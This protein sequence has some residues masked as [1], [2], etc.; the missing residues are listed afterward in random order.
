M[1]RSLST[2]TP[3][4]TLLSPS[5]AASRRAAQRLSA[6]TSFQ[7]CQETAPPT[8]LNQVFGVD[9]S[10]NSHTP[11]FIKSLLPTIQ[12]D[13][14][15][16]ECSE[17][18]TILHWLS[19][20]PHQQG[21]DDNHND[22]TLD[23]PHELLAVQDVA[24]VTAAVERI[25]AVVLQTASVPY[26]SMRHA[27]VGKPVTRM[28]LLANSLPILHLDSNNHS[29]SNRNNSS[30]N[31]ASRTTLPLPSSR[32]AARPS[33]A[34]GWLKEVAIPAYNDEM[35]LA[36]DTLMTQFTNSSLARPAVGLYQLSS[37]NSSNSNNNNLCLRPLPAAKE[38]RKLPPPSLVFSTHSVDHVQ[39]LASAMTVDDI[40]ETNKD[41]DASS[42]TATVA[43][44]R[45]GKI[46]YTG[47]GV[48]QIMLQ[49]TDWMGLDVRFCQATK[50]S[51]M[52]AEAQESLL[53]GSLAEL[54]SPHVLQGGSKQ[55]KEGDCWAEFRA[56]LK[57]PSGFL[58]RTAKPSKIAKAP[59]LPYE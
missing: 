10:T 28:H 12:W 47:N 29:N 20:I 25:A 48:G 1:K 35:D 17:S 56:N 57:H 5:P 50:Y 19:P 36:G 53:A 2:A 23:S 51:S 9:A 52:F 24:S 6:W 58:Q 22:T 34:I 31:A 30:S 11:S 42:P 14:V 38:D 21:N 7:H 15:A 33:G 39:E 44:V 46:G 43:V 27:V 8:A 45:T 55:V 59:D 40:K 4:V 32:T 3:I 54:Q 37:N 49:T 13:S 26:L 18:G 41:K 16:L